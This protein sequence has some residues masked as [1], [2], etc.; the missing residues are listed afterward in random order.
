[1][2]INIL[3]T[4]SA[5][6]ID[7]LHV[8][9]LDSSGDL[10]GMLAIYTNQNATTGYVLHNLNMTPYLGQPVKLRFDGVAAGLPTQTVFELDNVTLTVQ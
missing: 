5:S 4:Q 10:L 7:R 8:Q 2:H 1:L 3:G 9:V 6:V